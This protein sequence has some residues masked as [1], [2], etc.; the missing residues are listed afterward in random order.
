MVEISRDERILKAGGQDTTEARRWKNYYKGQIQKLVDQSKGFLKRDYSAERSYGNIHESKT[1]QKK[2]GRVYKHNDRGLPMLRNYNDYKEYVEKRYPDL[3][4]NEDY[5]KEEWVKILENNNFKSGYRITKT[6]A[7][8]KKYGIEGDVIMSLSNFAY[9]MSRHATDYKVDHFL[10]IKETIDNYDFLFEGDQPGN[11]DFKFYKLF[12]DPETNK[13]YG[14][15]VAID[16]PGNEGSEF[17][18]HL[19]YIGPKGNKPI[20][21]IRILKGKNTLIDEKK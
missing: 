9:I 8:L 11:R 13:T 17:V 4:K 3:K 14:I 21:K 19:N 18:V 5:S 6:P 15:E 20:K 1:F 10:S 2:S 7:V 12:I 16:R